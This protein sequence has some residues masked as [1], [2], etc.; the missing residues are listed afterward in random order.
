MSSHDSDIDSESYIKTQ[1]LTSLR[2][3]IGITVMTEKPTEEETELTEKIFE[4]RNAMVDALHRD[5]EDVTM[6]VALVASLQC[7][8]DVLC[9][10]GSDMPDVLTGVIAKLTLHGT[11]HMDLQD[12]PPKGVTFTGTVH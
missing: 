8:E 11:Q 4:T 7:L 6:I 12:N 3:S 1:I 5:D 9:N 10:Y 2:L